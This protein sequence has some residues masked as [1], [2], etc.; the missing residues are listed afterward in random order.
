M[1]RS[2]IDLGGMLAK[3]GRT[4]RRLGHPHRDPL[5]EVCVDNAMPVNVHIGAWDTAID[6]LTQ[7]RCSPVFW[8]W[9]FTFPAISGASMR[10]VPMASE[11]RRTGR[12][13]RSLG[14]RRSVLQP[15]SHR[16]QCLAARQ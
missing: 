9:G 13:E 15:G 10:V 14:R 12:G 4:A 3:A 7:P 6:W 11:G 2:V 1:P 5:W 16:H 8:R